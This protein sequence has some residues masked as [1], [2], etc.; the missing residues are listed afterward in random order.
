MSAFDRF[1]SKAEELAKKA[2]PKAE[3]LREKAKPLAQTFMEKAERAGESLKNKADDVAEGFRQGTEKA[4][5]SDDKP[6][7]EPEKPAEPGEG[8]P[9]A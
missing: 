9:E 3:E 8:K 1:K 7:T 2:K 6:A 4:R 5:P